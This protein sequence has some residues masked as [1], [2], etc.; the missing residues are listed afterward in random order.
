MVSV[1]RTFFNQACWSVAMCLSRRSHL[2]LGQV[3]VR[4][5]WISRKVQAW[6]IDICLGWPGL[7]IYDFFPPKILNCHVSQS[8]NWPGC[9][10]E[11]LICHYDPKFCFV[12][13]YLFWALS[14]FIL[15]YF[16]GVFYALYF[17][18]N[19]TL[20]AFFCLGGAFRLAFQFYLHY[21]PIY[22]LII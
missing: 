21:M 3:W 20:C 19:I 14:F 5:S 17:E 16:K 9:V 18:F 13:S 15:K 7:K 11:T 6:S 4:P 1:D 22:G 8:L 12:L 10:A 2:K